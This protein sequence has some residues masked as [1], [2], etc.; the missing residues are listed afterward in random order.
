MR[1]SHIL[2]SIAAVA[3]A[4]S[5][6]CGGIG[7]GPKKVVVNETVCLN[8]GFLRLDT[9][10]T[11][12]IVVDNSAYSQGQ[13]QF[14]LRLENFP[15][16]VK[17]EVPPNSTIGSPFSTITLIAKPGEEKHVDIVPTQTGRYNATCGVIVGSR[18]TVLDLRF[19]IF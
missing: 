17:G 14:T 7:G 5:S 18:T 13:T 10:K 2:A 12:R 6:A 19:Q 16:V 1:R 11:Q 4:L 9:G 3:L 15:V 8:A